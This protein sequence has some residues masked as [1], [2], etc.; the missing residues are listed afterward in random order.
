MAELESVG[1]PLLVHGGLEFLRRPSNG[2]SCGM[3]R[4]SSSDTSARIRSSA[5]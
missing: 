3:T 1:K 2:T 4:P 5:T